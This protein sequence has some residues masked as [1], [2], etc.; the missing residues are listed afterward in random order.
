MC[1]GL[2]S[3]SMTTRRIEVA[4]RIMRRFAP[5]ACVCFLGRLQTELYEIEL[6]INATLRSKRPLG[7]TRVLL[8]GL[9]LERSVR[10][11]PSSRSGFALEG[12]SWS[13]NLGIA[14]IAIQHLFHIF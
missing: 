1:G 13:L 6:A 2:R 3:F 8:W 10:R 9:S 12:L 11:K 7:S 14:V 4:N 5:L